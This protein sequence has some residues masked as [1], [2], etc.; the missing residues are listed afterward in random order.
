MPLRAENPAMGITRRRFLGGCL[1]AGGAA[2]LGCGDDATM[3]MPVRPPDG[4]DAAPPPILC[5]DPFA[6]GTLDG[7]LDLLDSGNPP[8][9]KL[10]GLGL[11]A[12]LYTDLAAIAPDALVTPPDMYYVRTSAP[13]GLAGQEPWKIAIDGLVAA[14]AT[15]GVADLGAPREMGTFVM[16]C[17]G[18]ETNDAFALMSAGTW[19]G[20]Q[21]AD[22]LARVQPT[23]DA[24]Q[25]LVAGYDRHDEPTV[26]STPGAS[27]IFRRA[28]L[29]AAGAFLATHEGGAPLA[30]DH[31]APVRLYVPNWYGC[32]CIKWVNH[33]QLVGDGAPATDQMVEFA[34]R[35]MQPGVPALA[36]DYQPATIDQAAMATRVERWQV[37][38]RTRYRVVGILWGGDKPTD[39]LQLRTTVGGAYQPVAVCPPMTTNATWTLWST[40]WDPPGP[41]TYE[42]ACRIADPSVRQRRLDAGWYARRVKIT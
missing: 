28:D 39:Q 19:R 9:G 41:G 22:V 21:L 2:A 11:D 18:N 26:T 7:T 30:P 36:R 24:T 3:S 32:A 42:L 23:A 1:A 33:I 17:S 27:W 10:I 31:G 34:H 35:T 25:V 15:L 20:V 12:R 37:G 40:A 29:D 13:D 14:P 4:P 38:G 16:E 5:D 6:G 8:F